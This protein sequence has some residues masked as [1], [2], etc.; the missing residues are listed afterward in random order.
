[1][2]SRNAQQ[3]VEFVL[4]LPI[5]I[6]LVMTIIE[7]GFAINMKISLSEAIKISMSQAQE[8]YDYSGDAAT[9]VTT[10]QNNLKAEIGNYFT[11]HN[12]LFANTLTVSVAPVTGM[13]NYSVIKVTS[14]YIPS[15]SLPNVLGG[16]VIPSFY[17]LSSTAM[18]NNSILGNNSAF[19]SGISNDDVFS[20]YTSE[21]TSILKNPAIDG[22]TNV[23]SLIGFLVDI[24]P[25]D[26][27]AELYDWQGNNISPGNEFD[28]TSGNLFIP[29]GN[30]FVDA[31]KTYLCSLFGSQK[32]T[33][34]SGSY[35]PSLWCSSPT[36][37][38]SD[39]I[40]DQSHDYLN[41]RLISFIEDSSSMSIGTY[42]P[43]LDQKT[44]IATNK[45]D[46][47]KG[48]VYQNGAKTPLVLYLNSDLTINKPPDNC[49]SIPANADTSQINT[50]KGNAM[51]PGVF[52]TK[53]NQ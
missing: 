40:S 36:C 33:F 2:K 15:F 21:E 51:N 25:L 16:Q 47:M 34:I 37:L 7:I 26:A 17:V 13:S 49:A 23:R 24:N 44:I 27:K 20:N 45:F 14:Q 48:Y 35:S 5:L 3:L 6:I 38:T 43:I 32:T 1:M 11:E 42:D 46:Q 39:D 12:L 19:D 29:S 28:L 10:F 50:L 8:M 41:K 30:V 53:V 52:Y 4:V 18:I 31:N 22:I 9:R